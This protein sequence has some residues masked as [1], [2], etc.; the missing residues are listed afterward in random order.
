MSD[1]LL[2]FRTPGPMMHG[3]KEAHEGYGAADPYAPVNKPCAC[4][5]CGEQ[6]TLAVSAETEDEI[7]TY[8]TAFGGDVI[9][10]DVLSWSTDEL[11]REVR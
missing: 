10:I 5:V 4:V 6:R 7:R 11:V 1:Y 9:S 8:V 2:R 3:M